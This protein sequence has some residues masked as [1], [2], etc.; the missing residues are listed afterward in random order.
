VPVPNATSNYK[1]VK[2]FTVSG[3]SLTVPEQTEHLLAEEKGKKPDKTGARL[4]KSPRQSLVVFDEQMA[5]WTRLRHQHEMKQNC[6]IYI[7]KR[8]LLFKNM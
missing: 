4:V 6:C 7:Y 2:E 1:Y 5:K 3:S 8:L